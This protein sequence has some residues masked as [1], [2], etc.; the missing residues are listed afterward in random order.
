MPD[1]SRVAMG[2]VIVPSLDG[3]LDL[4]ETLADGVAM[5]PDARQLFEVDRRLLRDQ[6]GVLRTYFAPATVGR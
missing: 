4:I 5:D 1:V 3:L 6:I 2:H